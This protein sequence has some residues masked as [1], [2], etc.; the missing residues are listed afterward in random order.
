LRTAPDNHHRPGGPRSI[1]APRRVREVGG[2]HSSDPWD[3]ILVPSFAETSFCQS[4]RP[5]R[6]EGPIYENLSSI[7]FLCQT[8]PKSTNLSARFALILVGGN[9]WGASGGRLTS[10]RFVR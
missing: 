5:A 7:R 4:P 1:R 9:G 10:F 3:E 6:R 8:S 2:I